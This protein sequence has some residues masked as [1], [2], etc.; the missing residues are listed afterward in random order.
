[1]ADQEVSLDN[2]RP[3]EKTTAP[4]TTEYT[5]FPIEPVR[6]DPKGDP[7]LAAGTNLS[8]EDYAKFEAKQKAPNKITVVAPKGSAGEVSLDHIRPN[9]GVPKY[10][11][12]GQE[13][14]SQ[15]EP[16]DY[17][18]GAPVLVRMDFQAAENPEEKALALGQYYPPEDFGQTKEGEWWVKRDGKKVP[19]LPSDNSW[20]AAASNFGTGAL[21]RATPIAGASLGAAAGT[22]G[23]PG[24][25]ALGAGLGAM[26]G[27]A[28]QQIAK[29]IRGISKQAPGEA[30]GNLA[31]QGALNTIMQGALPGAAMNATRRGYF[32]VTPESQTR[33]QRL[34][35]ES[36][37]LSGSTP[38]GN[39]KLQVPFSSAL[40][41]S[42]VLPA[43]QNFWNKIISPFGLQASKDLMKSKVVNMLAKAGF[44]EHQIADVVRAVER[45]EEV[46]APQR[47]GQAI[48][49]AVQARQQL[50]TQALAQATKNVE[51]LTKQAEDDVARL[52]SNTD[53][54]LSR[55]LYERLVQVR[56]QMSEA[57]SARYDAINAM[58]GNEEVVPLE[59]TIMAMR[60]FIQDEVPEGVPLPPIMAR[61]AQ[62]VTKGDAKQAAEGA[63]AEFGA[64][65]GMDELVPR[66]TATIKEVQDTRAWI[67][68]YTLKAREGSLTPG[69]PYHN[70]DTVEKALT[71]A[72]DKAAES[73]G[74]TADAVRALKETNAAYKGDI[75]RFKSTSIRGIVRDAK[76]GVFANP[77]VIAKR[78]LGEGA[79]DE[80]RQVMS[81]L[82]PEMQQQV[83]KVYVDDMLKSVTRPNAL[84]GQA[85]IDAQLLA[86]VLQK[87]KRIF[88]T[89]MPPGLSD[90]LRRLAQNIAA[91]DLKVLAP[92]DLTHLS[93]G[94]IKTALEARLARQM[95][96]D[97][98]VQTDAPALFMAGVRGDTEAFDT[99][100]R[101]AVEP[102]RS[103]RTAEVM[104]LLG[105][106]EGEH[107]RQYA[108]NNMLENS[109]HSDVNG[110]VTINSEALRANY[111]K[112]SPQQREL[113]FPNG[114]ADD[115]LQLIAD[116]EFL[117]PKPKSTGAGT[118]LAAAAIILHVGLPLS[119]AAM[120][121]DAKF[122]LV[123]LNSYLWT[124]QPVVKFLAVEGKRD[125]TMM[126]KV[127]E[128]LRFAAL[129][130]AL[131]GKGVDKPQQ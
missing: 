73:G 72:L 29:G 13:A 47:A 40:P 121:A 114:I 11:T 115:M 67:R 82:P 3:R 56:K 87:N 96:L 4:Q 118:S 109:M 54:A 68:N 122:A 131:S 80:A 74:I 53:P 113:L 79:I 10:D 102:G 116:N 65:H 50:L 22:T 58:T 7:N 90:G 62:R 17:S 12:A 70:F 26:G 128:L 99:A 84:T 30:M 98:L 32:G 52:F 21:S 101:W 2:I 95:E 48:A 42:K 6:A 9:A 1:M 49:G 55:L 63:T 81:L 86:E 57:Y 24:G 37:A 61:L 5:S 127:S 130:A 8:P 51:M 27:Y 119:Y 78:V 112:F 100:A 129:Q 120:H 14:A 60:R 41:D 59:D 105:P 88:D 23:G 77:E 71:K 15:E 117:F 34:Q 106:E 91:K 43:T 94:G 89:F 125:P 36:K 92:E 19:V 64:N 85:T 104:H 75:A 35:N 97:A 108:W 28:T 110:N 16:I 124:R 45:G 76:D 107:V 69:M 33:L 38:F 20:G 39:A 103:A 18:R 31:E 111:N 46:V 66:D 83:G 123:A 44:P 25:M 93:P 126:A